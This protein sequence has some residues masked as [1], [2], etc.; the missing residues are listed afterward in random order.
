[1]I[2]SGG[3]KKF[4]KTQLFLIKKLRNFK[5]QYQRKIL[6]TMKLG[7]G[8]T[9]FF[10]FLGFLFYKKEV[11]GEGD[12]TVQKKNKANIF[13]LGQQGEDVKPVGKTGEAKCPSGYHL[14]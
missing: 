1:M 6:L 12:K 10:T 8:C 14:L 9:T 2:V 11:M 7:V 3:Q 13:R 5:T 4:Y